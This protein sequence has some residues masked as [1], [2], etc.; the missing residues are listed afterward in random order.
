MTDKWLS[1]GGRLCI[2]TR[3]PDLILQGLAFEQGGT[4]Q[5]YGQ[6]TWNAMVAG[7]VA[8]SRWEWQPASVAEPTPPPLRSKGSTS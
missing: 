5:V 3:A 4:H 2:A 6:A 7:S 1:G 8:A